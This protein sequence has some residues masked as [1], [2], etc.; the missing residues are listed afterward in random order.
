MLGGIVGLR[1]SNIFA[2]S[3]I[4]YTISSKQCF[5]LLNACTYSDKIIMITYLYCYLLY[6][7]IYFKRRLLIFY[8]I[9]FYKDFKLS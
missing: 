2:S 3:K 7:F 1:L 9:L 5:P 4:P 8:S 6:F